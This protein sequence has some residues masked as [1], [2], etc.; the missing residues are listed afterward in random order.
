MSLVIIS[1]GKKH[2]SHLKDLIDGYQRRLRKPFDID[3]S[4]IAYSGYSGISA[5]RDES[6]RIQA[7]LKPNQFVILLDERGLQL[8]SPALSQ[9]IEAQ[10][11]CGKIPVFIIGGAY[12]VDDELR[13][14]ADLIW[15][16]SDLVFPHALVRL[17][18][19]EQLYRAQAIAKGEPYHHE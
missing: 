6:Q 16:L 3:W 12:G 8:T 15:S 13:S 9:L 18:L 14:R 7:L 2:R 4:F 11:S 1:V 10:I 5:A 17:M 19:A